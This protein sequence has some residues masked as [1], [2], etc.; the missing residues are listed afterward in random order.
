MK[1]GHVVPN[2]DGSKAR[3]GGPLICPACALEQ[4]Q[5]IKSKPIEKSVTPT[6]PEFEAWLEKLEELEKKATPW[7][8]VN[9]PHGVVQ[10]QNESVT[11]PREGIIFWDDD[12]K[13]NNSKGVANYEFIAVSRT[14][15]SKLLQIVRVQREALETVQCDSVGVEDWLH[16]IATDALAK[17]EELLK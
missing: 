7:P 14:A 17:A 3:C 12:G 5:Q 11:I 13:E 10:T 2:L 4:A 8:W 6:H 9:R 16:R 1:H 15:L